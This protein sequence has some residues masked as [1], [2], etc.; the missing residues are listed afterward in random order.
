M[1]GRTNI[2]LLNGT[3]G[4]G[5]VLKNSVLAFTRIKS[6]NPGVLVAVN[7]TKEMLTVN[8]SAISGV[9]EELTVHLKST[10]FSVD[11]LQV[12]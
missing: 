6:G 4:D 5:T 1:H 8:F 10:G 7:P 11:D 12:K 3:L 2:T 9:A